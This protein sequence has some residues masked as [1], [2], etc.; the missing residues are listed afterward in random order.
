MIV[1]RR[2][3][4]QVVQGPFVLADS[5]QEARDTKTLGRQASA[6]RP[7]VGPAFLVP[8]RLF[9]PHP[10]NSMPAAARLKVQT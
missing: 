8:V 3:R 4:T 7:A 9:S 1:V 6:V 5:D 2:I 10:P